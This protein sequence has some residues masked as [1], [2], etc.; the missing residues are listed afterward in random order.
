MTLDQSQLA[1]VE[2]CLGDGDRV[3]T[4]GAGTGKTTIIKALVEQMNGRVE[5][6]CPTGKAAARL[7]EATGFEART[8]HSLMLWDG[9]AFRRQ[10]DFSNCVIVDESSMVD[11]WLM[12]KLLSFNPKKLVLV[13]DASQLA[14]VGRGQPFHDLCA[15]RPDIVSTLTTCH[16]AK[17]A[18]HIAAQLIREGRAPEPALSSGGETWAMRETGGPATTFAALRKWIEGGAYDPNRDL[19]ISPQYGEAGGEG[20]T[21][22]A[23]GGIHSINRMVKE[24]LNPAKDGEK[25]SVGDR[26]IITKNFAA[27]DLWN[28]DLGRVEAVDTKGF[29][30]V[31]LDRDAPKPEDLDDGAG[32]AK[33]LKKEQLNHLQ[34]AYALSVHKAQGSQCRRVFFVVFRKHLRM[35]SK[36]LI[37]TAVTRAK[38]GCVVMGELGSFYSGINTV[39]IRRTVLQNLFRKT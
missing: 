35:L 22:D 10:G 11:S 27:D 5:L 19:I 39:Q 31:L 25:F 20:A 29:P 26:V 8:L 7:R 21:P 37:Y 2:A 24:L 3:I 4:G 16:R 30:Y 38:E 15:L 1:A 9:T 34:H 18:V 36:A 13:G 14:P 28:G 6:A 32:K 33:L 12:A 17:G 23:D